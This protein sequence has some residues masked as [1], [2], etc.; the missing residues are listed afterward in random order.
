MGISKFSLQSINQL[1]LG[2]V[3]DEKFPDFVSDKAG[4]LRLRNND[5]QNLI[6]VPRTG[7]AHEGFESG[8]KLSFGEPE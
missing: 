7:F 2:I 5:I 1:W 4:T 6:A 3:V 8:I